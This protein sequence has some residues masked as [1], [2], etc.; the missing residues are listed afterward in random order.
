MLS[1]ASSGLLVDD[2][3]GVGM[4]ELDDGAAPVSSVSDCGRPVVVVYCGSVI[5]RNLEIGDMSLSA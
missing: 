5:W 4:L 2:G 1:P 3:P